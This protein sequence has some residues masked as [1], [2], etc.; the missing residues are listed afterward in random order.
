MFVFDDLLEV[1]DRGIQTLLRGVSTEL[2]K[3]ALKG[4]EEELKTKILKNM[5]KRAS[6]ML[7]EDMEV[8]GPVKLS[9]VEVAQKEILAIAKKLEDAGDIHLS[10]GDDFV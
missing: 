10:S 9:D 4:A 7:I 3:V 2:L 1:E 6:E 8:T 5:S